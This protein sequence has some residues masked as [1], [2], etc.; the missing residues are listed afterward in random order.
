MRFSKKERYGE[1][2]WSARML[3]MAKSK[4]ERLA[5]KDRERLPLFAD[6][7]EA[8]PAVDIKDQMQ[9]RQHQY[10]AAEKRMRD[11]DAKH[12]RKGRAIYFGATPDQRAQ[13]QEQWNAWRGPLKPGYFIY[14]AECVTGIYEQRAQAC[15]QRDRELRMKALQQVDLQQEIEL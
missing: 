9:R 12:W 15:R 2:E 13:I 1:I 7:I 14:V 8:G 11:L 3:A 5:K 6:Q 10:D 4:P